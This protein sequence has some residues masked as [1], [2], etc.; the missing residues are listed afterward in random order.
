MRTMSSKYKKNHLFVSLHQVQFANR[1]YLKSLKR[2]KTFTVL[3]T[4]PLH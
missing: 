4:Q 2:I 1:E 3:F